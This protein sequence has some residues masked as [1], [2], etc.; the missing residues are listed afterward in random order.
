MVCVEAGACKTLEIKPKG[1]KLVDASGMAGRVHAEK[2]VHAEE[3]Q[4]W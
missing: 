2:V 3:K 1:A 4:E